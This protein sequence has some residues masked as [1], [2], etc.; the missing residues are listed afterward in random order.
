MAWP[1][2]DISFA[3]VKILAQPPAHR[4]YGPEGEPGFGYPQRGFAL[5][6]FH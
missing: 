5:L 3:G 6:E 1:V 4:A 2:P